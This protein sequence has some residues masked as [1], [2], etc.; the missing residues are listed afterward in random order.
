[1]AEKAG[2]GAHHKQ[3]LPRRPVEYDQ[4]IERHSNYY[5]SICEV[6]EKIK[7]YELKDWDPSDIVLRLLKIEISI[8]D[9]VMEM[10]SKYIEDYE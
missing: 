3:E 2:P 7:S 4:L 5:D 8:F 10:R 9:A 1:M 6:H